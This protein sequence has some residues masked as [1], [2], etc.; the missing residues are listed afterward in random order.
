[1]INLTG[2]QRTLD[3]FR[4]R[5][6]NVTGSRCGDLMK[7][8]RAKTEP[9]SETAKSYM[10]QLAAERTMNP[11]VVE[12]D[13]L[14]EEYIQ[15]VEVTSKAMRF[16]TEQEANARELLQKMANAEIT[17][18]SSCKHDTIEHFAASPDGVFVIDLRAVAC[19]EIK[20]PKQEAFMKYQ[21]VVDGESLKKIMP[22]YYWQTQAEMACTGTD[23]CYFA[24]YSPWQKNP[25]HVALIERS[26][27]DVAQ[28]EER[29]KMANDWIDNLLSDG[30]RCRLN[31]P[32]IFGALYER[33]LG[34]AV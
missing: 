6:G 14:F 32:G 4:A 28:L 24:A 20:C 3:W 27:E 1:M 33:A 16:G 8:G 31:V 25:L 10:L 21:A 13:E 18:P 7:S 15:C 5:L 30:E 29:V 23:M 2:E 22:Q 34:K 9:W 26:A 17:E 12:N 11:A 19:V